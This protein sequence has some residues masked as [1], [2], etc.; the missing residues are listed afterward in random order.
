MC[1]PCATVKSFLVM[2]IHRVFQCNFRNYSLV[3]KELVFLLCE[4]PLQGIIIVIVV[5]RYVRIM[6]V[7]ILSAGTYCTC[8]PQSSA[9]HGDEAEGCG[10]A[11][12]LPHYHL[13]PNTM[14]QSSIHPRQVCVVC[15]CVCVCVCA[16]ASMYVGEG[17]GACTYVSFKRTVFCKSNLPAK[18]HCKVF[19][20]T[21]LSLYESHHTQFALCGSHGCYFF[22]QTSVRVLLSP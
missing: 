18:N 22:F 15:V 20:C 2:Q 3:Y 19:V 4:K 10:E 21:Y 16:R 11:T 7:S 14:A 5:L 13:R 6:V 9:V 17:N 12:S 8:A 1:V